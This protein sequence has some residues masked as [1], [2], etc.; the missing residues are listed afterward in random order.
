MN[1]PN[2]LTVARIA[3]IPLLVLF[4]YLPVA[5][6]G[7]AAVLTFLLAA[8]TDALDG[9]LARKLRQTSAPGAFLDPVADKLLVAVALILVIDR[10]DTLWVTLPALI[11]IWREIAVSALREWMASV[12]HQDAV[13]VS[14][15]GK[16]KTA[17]Q[18]AALVVL[19]YQPTAYA[20]TAWQI[21]GV[22]MLLAAAMMTVAS[23]AEYLNAAWRVMRQ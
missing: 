15:A 13:A 16:L 8:L 1:L 14:W 22:A 3:L 11:I 17:M 7:L 4:F 12:G 9:Y 6:G 20:A 2:W 18:M 23:V 19:L 21:A 10:M 5:W